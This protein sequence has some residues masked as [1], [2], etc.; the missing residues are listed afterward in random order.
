LRIAGP[1]AISTEILN[2][3]AKDVIVGEAER[4][5]AELIVMGSHGYRGLKKLWFGSVSQ[6]VA[7]H[8]PCSVEIVRP[9][10]E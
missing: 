7:L 3:V 9:S 6:A 5:G 2:G 4:W 1:L 8:A 10:K